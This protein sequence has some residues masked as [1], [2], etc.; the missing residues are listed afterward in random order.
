MKRLKI[1]FEG[2][3]EGGMADGEIVTRWL[4]GGDM[5]L[6]FFLRENLV[7]IDDVAPKHDLKVESNG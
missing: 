6:N 7:F 3:D 5:N 4:D 1:T 2:A